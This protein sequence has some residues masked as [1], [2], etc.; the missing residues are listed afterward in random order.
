MGLRPVALTS[1]LVKCMDRVVMK[2]AT[3]AVVYQL[4]PT[5]Y[6]YKPQR[7]T[8]AAT[9]ILANTVARQLHKH[10]LRQGLSI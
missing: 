1:L 4:D 10:M 3:S 9:L 5:Q 7:G 6:A 8:E 2:H